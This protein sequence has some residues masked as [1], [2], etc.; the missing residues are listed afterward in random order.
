MYILQTLEKYRKWFIKVN[1]LEKKRHKLL[2]EKEK[3]AAEK[4]KKDSKK[5]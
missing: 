2:K 5:M 3:L 4:A 1:N